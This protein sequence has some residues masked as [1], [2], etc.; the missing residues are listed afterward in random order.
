MSRRPDGTTRCDKCG[1]DCENGAVT[2]CATISTLNPKDPD[3]PVVLHLCRHPRDGAPRGCEGLTLGP[4][5]LAN[6]HETRTS[7]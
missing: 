7:P 4:A 1:R 5:T 3:E 2:V 6:F